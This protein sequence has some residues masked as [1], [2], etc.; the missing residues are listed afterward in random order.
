MEMPMMGM[1]LAMPNIVGAVPGV[2]RMPTIM[3]KN[4]IKKKGVAS[5]PELRESAI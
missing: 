3:M 2:V 5:I 1:H 4:P